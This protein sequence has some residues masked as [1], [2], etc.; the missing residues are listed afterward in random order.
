M[1]PLPE[2]VNP[3]LH[4]R[5]NVLIGSWLRCAQKAVA[6]RDVTGQIDGLLQQWDDA[7][8]AVREDAQRRSIDLGPMEAVQ[9]HARKPLEFQLIERVKLAA[10]FKKPIADLEKLLLKLAAEWTPVTPAQ[11]TP[12]KPAELP[13]IWYHGGKSYSTDGKNPCV[14]SNHQ[15]R[16]VLQKFLDQDEAF[17]TS[18]LQSLCDNVS[19]TIHEIEEQFGN[20]VTR[21]PGKGSG[22]YIRVRSLAR[23]P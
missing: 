14:V 11:Q 22:Y 17:E 19:R 12:P 23:M 2:S 9:R 20:A 13:T 5:N 3:Y 4:F 8:S 21:N 18:D 6:G 15:Q 1:S 16:N 10:A 7:L